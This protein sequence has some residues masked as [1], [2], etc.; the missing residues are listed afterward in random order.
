MPGQILERNL[1][2][3]RNSLGRVIGDDVA[4]LEAAVGI[5]GLFWLGGDDVNLRRQS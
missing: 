3:I 1:E 2:A 5:V 4:G